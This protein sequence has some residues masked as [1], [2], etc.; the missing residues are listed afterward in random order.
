MPGQLKHFTDKNLKCLTLRD[1]FPVIILCHVN[2]IHH[3]LHWG[4]GGV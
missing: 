2:Q 4:D 1:D 3:I